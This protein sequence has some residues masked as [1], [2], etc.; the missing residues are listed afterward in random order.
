MHT[1]DNGYR[2]PLIQAQ[3]CHTPH[4]YWCHEYLERYI[5]CVVSCIVPIHRAKIGSSV[6]VSVI[7]GE[8]FRLVVEHREM[9]VD[10][11]RVVEL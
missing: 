6:T 7:D 9:K 1:D 3:E 10:S 2:V 8:Y 4:S 11:V 5:S